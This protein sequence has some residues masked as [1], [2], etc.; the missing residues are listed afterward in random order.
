VALDGSHGGAMGKLLGYLTG[1]LVETGCG[2]TDREL[3]EIFSGRFEIESIDLIDDDEGRPFRFE[4]AL[5]R[6]A[7]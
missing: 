2:F 5:M 3:R 1:P 4:S 7:V 6:L